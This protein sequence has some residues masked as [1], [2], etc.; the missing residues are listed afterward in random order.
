MKH[1]IDLSNWGEFVV[2]DLFNCETTKSMNP[3]KDQLPEGN[4]PYITRSGFNNGV[5]GY[6]ADPENEFTTKGQCITIGAEGAIAFYQELDFIPG[7][8]VYTLRHD[9]LTKKSALFLCSLLNANSYKYSYTNARIL[10][11]IKEE[12]IKL[13]LKPNTDLNNYTQS[14]IDWDYM[15]NFMK[16]VQE[17]AKERLENLPKPGEKSKTPIDVSTWGEFK[18]GE[19]FE[20]E[21][22]NPLNPKSDKPIPGNIPF[23]TST[24]ISNGIQTRYESPNKTFINNG[25][26][27]SISAIGK[28]AFY[29]KEP[30]IAAYKVY[31]LRHKKMN[32]LSGLFICSILNSIADNYSYANIRAMKALKQEIIKLPLKPNT[33]PNNYTQADIDWEYMEKFME[34]MQNKAK[35]RLDKLSVNFIN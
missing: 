29:Q 21:T 5:S 18:M 25:D 2:G 30:F 11:R 3:S 14:D 33:N 15:E 6:Y 20:C 13:P 9:N 34:N 16:K 12:T 17:K 26:C 8:K 19:L 27:I 28:L 1:P 24:V 31:A 4:I 7:I 35:A 10:D 22:T 32:F 23:I